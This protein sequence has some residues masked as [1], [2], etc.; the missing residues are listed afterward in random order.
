MKNA[1]V[2]IYRQLF[3]WL[4]VLSSLG[5]IPR[6]GNNGSYGNYVYESSLSTLAFSDLEGC[7]CEETCY[8]QWPESMDQV[9]TPLWT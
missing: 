3:V 5:F 2:N 4:C 8:S 7:L 6:S 1:A 9:S